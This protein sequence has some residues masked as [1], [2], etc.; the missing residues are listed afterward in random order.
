[1]GAHVW[2]CPQSKRQRP[3]YCSAERIWAVG[4][5]SPPPLS[6]CPLGKCSGLDCSFLSCSEVQT[7]FKFKLIHG[8]CVTDFEITWKFRYFLDQEML[9]LRETEVAL[10]GQSCAEHP[11]YMSR[12][13]M[14]GRGGCGGQCQWETRQKGCWDTRAPLTPSC[15]CTDVASPIPQTLRA[16]RHW[17][18]KKYISWH[19]CMKWQTRKYKYQ[20]NRK[21]PMSGCESNCPLHQTLCNPNIVHLIVDKGVGHGFLQY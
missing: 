7:V 19:G 14:L 11:L 15:C 20:R 6:D 21:L 5:L 1:M 9:S 13:I 18:I 17:P 10:L 2:P 12:Y 3:Q 4:G 8:N 16:Q